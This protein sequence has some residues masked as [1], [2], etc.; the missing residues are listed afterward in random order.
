[1]GA[2]VMANGDLPSGFTID[3]PAAAA[4]GADLPAGFTLD[5]PP[6]SQPQAP[7]S[8][9]GGVL[10]FR[11]DQSGISF[12]PNAGL[13]GAFKTP[14]DFTYGVRTGAI[15]ADV[16]NPAYIGGAVDTALTYGPGSVASRAG[17]GG[18]VAPANEAIDTAAETGFKNY[19]Q[20]LQMYPGDEYRTLLQTTADNLRKAG[21]HDVPEGA[22]VP[23]AIINRELERVKN[24]PFVTSEDLDALRVQLSAKGLRGQNLPATM[25]ARNDLFSYIDKNLPPGSDA[26]IAGAV[27][28]YRQARHSDVVTGKDEATSQKN[29]A[30]AQG[31]ELSAEQTRTNIANLINSRKGLGPQGFSDTEMNILRTANQATPAIDRAQRL[32]DALQWRGGG[33]VLSGVGGGGAGTALATGH[34]LLAAGLAVSG[35][36]P[37]LA[38]A[39]ARTYANRGARQLAEQADNAIR[40]QSPLAQQNLSTLPSNFRATPS[41]YAATSGGMIEAAME[42]RRREMEQRRQTAPPTYRVLPDGTVEELS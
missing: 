9:T 13:L 40:M 33:G 19:R 28:N 23:H 41:P 14:F 36:I 18:L 34:P 1:M 6:P 22:A 21:Y 25:Q 11:R 10:P 32:G 38:G 26:S 27:G 4:P 2:D 42:A 15:P 8:Y 24:Q 12:D 20:S 29:I 17:K 7:T 30:K 35:T 39:A 31:S 3:T 37:G 5:P 16:R